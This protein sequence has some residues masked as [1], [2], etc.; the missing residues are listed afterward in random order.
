MLEEPALAQEVESS[1]DQVTVYRNGA[2]VA[3]EAT[4]SLKKGRNEVTFT[5]L[6]PYLN[7]ETIQLSGSGDF[8]ILSITHQK[9]YLGQQPQQSRLQELKTRRDSLER[10]I[11]KKQTTKSVLDQELNILLSNTNLK[12][13]QQNLS[14]AEL[15]KAMEY[16]HRKLTDLESGKLALKRELADLNEELEKINRQISELDDHARNRSVITAVFQADEAGQARV[17]LSYLVSRATWNPSYDVRV[18]DIESPVNLSYK[19]NIQQSTGVDW[20]DVNLEISSAVPTRG[21][22]LPE[23]SPW[24]IQFHEPRREKAQTT[25][26]AMLQAAPVPDQA[27]EDRAE[28]MRQAVPVQEMQNQ[29]SFSYQV[30][31]PY[32]VPSGGKGVAVE[33]KNSDIPAQ[34]RYYTVPKRR[35]Q[36]Y[37]TARVTD[38]NQYNLLPGEANLFFADTYVGRSSINPRAMG[39]TLSFSMGRDESVVVDREALREFEETNFFGNKVRKTFARKISVR[40][41]KSKPV[42]IEVLDQ[43]PVSQHEDIK[44]SLKEGTGARHNRQTGILTWQL[45]IKPG[46]TKEL[47]LVYEVEYPKGKD[48]DY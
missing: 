3:R 46:D 4:L 17:K 10:L 41:S 26:N 48:I 2:Q 24:Y 44:V 27:A 30:E 38:W 9:D 35:E 16:F 15:E 39:D 12:G 22:A 43:V 14:A 19:A 8:M 47:R 21:G 11:E 40:N 25:G 1:I 7:S 13:G 37:L 20:T 45:Q 33:I 36:A 32:N 28:Q 34:Y 42:D 18:S 6:S 31:V 29:T 5:G 23:L